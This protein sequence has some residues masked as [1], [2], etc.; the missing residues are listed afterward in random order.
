MTVT[1]SVLR[2]FRN[3]I[4]TRLFSGQSVLRHFKIYRSLSEEF[5]LRYEAELSVDEIATLERR[6]KVTETTAGTRFE[7]IIDKEIHSR[8]KSLS[9]TF[10]EQHQ[11]S[12][13]SFTQ[14]LATLISPYKYKTKAFHISTCSLVKKSTILTNSS[15]SSCSIS[16]DATRP[17]SQLQ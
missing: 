13:C 7:E 3:K 15:E 2:K 8:L 4:Y 17:H 14:S 10:L 6:V 11:S 12:D 9:T 5:I 1:R 16:D